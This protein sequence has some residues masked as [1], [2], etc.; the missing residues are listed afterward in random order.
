MN[1]Y[2]KKYFSIIFFAIFIGVY[3]LV[4]LI[5][6]QLGPTDDFIFLRTLQADKPL[7]YYSQ[8]FPYYDAVKLGRF[9]PLA[10]MEY[11]LFGLLSK[12]PSPL[13]YFF[14]H[15]I[16]FIIFAVLI[17][18]LIRKFTSD[19][20]LIYGIPILLFL[21][22]GFTI[23]WFRMQMNERNVIFFLAAF[24]LCY[25]AYLDKRKI[26]YFISA[27]L[28]ANFA[29][30]YKETAFIAI[31]AFAF[32]HFV[33]S[34]K[35]SDKR[36]KILD[37]SLALSSFLYAAI[38]YFYVY[39]HRGSNVY[40]GTNFN[41]LAFI[42]NFLNYGFFS[43]P[44]I[45]LVL[46][47][48]T[49]WRIY[50]LF[51]R[52]QEAHPILDS[53][54]ITG[55]VYASA[56]FI[57]N[58]YGPYYLLPVYLFAIPTIIY[59]FSQNEQKNIILKGLLLASGFVLLFN[60]IPS[61]IYYLTYYK[62]LPINFNKTLDFLIQDINFKYLSG[63]ANIFMD[64]VGRG[65]GRGAYFVLAEFLQYK[66][67]TANRFDLKSNSENE[68]HFS[69]I[70]KIPVPFTVFQ[71]DKPDEI[72]S[73]DYLIVSPQNSKNVNEEYLQ[74]LSNNYELAFR[75]KSALAF[76][77]INLK[78]LAKYF[79]LK[80]MSEGQKSSDIIINKNLTEWPDYYVFVKK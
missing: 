45:I 47:P 69:L 22:P 23:S 72:K 21:T 31:G 25:L 32:F 61:G 74:S 4:L 41:L 56:F 68:T 29:I 27:I 44:I 6:P 1:G 54:M 48:L 8:D 60:T 26:I 78:A 79:L 58:M 66:G 10:G 42:K 50:K 67:L 70:S 5:N 38:Y 30:Y 7:L 73:G 43:D 65:N 39:L 49:V 53:M 20:L 62:Y 35:I 28:F 24:F 18:K 77:N 13:W 3:A 9:T 76:P 51:V 57:L 12:S 64:G 59:F 11:N 15:T 75:T 71:N 33:F 52:K 19:K 63:Q 16:Q 46:L 55:S 2:S 80:R 17:V 37:G 34:R 40:G 14:F 36:V